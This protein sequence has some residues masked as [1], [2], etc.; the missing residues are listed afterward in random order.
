ML[1]YKT[2]ERRNN[3]SKQDKYE[4]LEICKECGGYCCKKSGCDYFVSDL[5]SMNLEYLES[6]LNLFLQFNELL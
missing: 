4:N 5:E 6:F 2:N 1:E 3:M